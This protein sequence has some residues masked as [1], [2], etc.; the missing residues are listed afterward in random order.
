MPM[1]FYAHENPKNT[2]SVLP[3]ATLREFVSSVMLVEFY[4]YISS[5]R[6]STKPTGKII[7]LPEKSNLPQKITVKS[8]MKSQ[9]QG[10]VVRRKVKK[11]SADQTVSYIL[12]MGGSFYLFPV[13]F[14]MFN[15]FTSAFESGKVY[16]LPNP[17]V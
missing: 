17:F 13:V 15:Y 8:K 12:T 10:G 9:P 2:S 5:Y 4:L 1:F 6:A 16:R 11:P 14:K 3:W 7:P